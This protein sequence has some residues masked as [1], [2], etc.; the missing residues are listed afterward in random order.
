MYRDT[1][2][3]PC[4]GLIYPTLLGFGGIQAIILSYK[5]S[6]LF[7]AINCSLIPCRLTKLISNSK[8]FGIYLG[9]LAIFLSELVFF[10]PWIAHMHCGIVTA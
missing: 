5:S 4:I 8:G 1:P 3:G 10:S 6:Y 2:R 7:G 9:Q